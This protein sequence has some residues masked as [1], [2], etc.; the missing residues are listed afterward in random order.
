MKRI[1]LVD[2]NESFRRPLASVL[3]QAGYSVECAADGT[4]AMN[5]FSEAAFD[6]VI[7][8]LIMPEKEGLETIA[9]MKELRPGAKI[10][11]ISGGGRVDA[12]DFLVVARHMGAIACLAKPFKSRD[13]L[14]LVARVLGCNGEMEGAPADHLFR[15]DL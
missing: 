11:A 2:D 6:L 9:E 14:E 4:Y 1:L 5:L 12:D 8:D 10:I 15:G 7:T 13:I 3:Q